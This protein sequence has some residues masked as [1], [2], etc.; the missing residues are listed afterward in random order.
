MVELSYVECSFFAL[1]LANQGLP[2]VRLPWFS[3]QFIPTFSDKNHFVKFQ[4]LKL[5]TKN[6]YH[7]LFWEVPA[8]VPVTYRE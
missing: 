6:F 2:T 8:P 5:S 1:F 7:E 3:D 4:V